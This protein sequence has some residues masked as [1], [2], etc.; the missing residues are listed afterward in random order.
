V[1]A[2]DFKKKME[3]PVHLDIIEPVIIDTD[4]DIKVDNKNDIETNNNYNIKNDIN[5]NI[6]IIPQKPKFSDTH[7]GIM[8]YIETELGDKLDNLSKGK[9]GMKS[10]I[11][12]EALRQFFKKNKI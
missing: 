1:S 2:M 12:N 8:I 11:V 10:Q 7:K 6:D 3:R 9:K 4:N 5:Y